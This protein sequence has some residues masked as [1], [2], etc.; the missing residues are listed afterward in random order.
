MVF[1]LTGPVPLLSCAEKVWNMPYL[2]GVTNTPAA[3]TAAWEA[4]QAG[5]RQDIQDIMILLSDGR[6]NVDED[7]VQGVAQQ[8]KD[9]GVT[10]FSIGEYAHL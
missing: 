5:Q 6:T 8:I 2:A 4:V 1:S 9:Q 7:T 10:I 3:L